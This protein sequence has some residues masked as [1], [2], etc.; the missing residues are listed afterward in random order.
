[1]D[2]N[3]NFFRPLMWVVQ[4]YV[5]MYYIV[6]TLDIAAKLKRFSLATMADVFR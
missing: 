3:F 5:R 6:E 1:M 4:Q 2:K